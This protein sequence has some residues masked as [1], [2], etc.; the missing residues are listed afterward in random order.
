[1]P[2]GTWAR[3]GGLVPGARARRAQVA[4]YRDEWAGANAR[5]IGAGRAGPLWVA[6]G[7]SAA[8]GVGASAYDRG[9]VGQVLAHLRSHADRRWR[10]VNLSVSGATAPDVLDVQVPQLRRLEQ[11]IHLVTCIVGGNDLLR[12]P[13]NV[14]ETAMLAI[15]VALPEGSYVANLP[16]G[17]RERKAAR[18]NPSIEKAARTHGHRVI[19]LWARTGPP[20]AGK[21]SADHFHPN[22]RGYADWA[23][24]VIAALQLPS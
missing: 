18:L 17:V 4:R 8:Q 9:Y 1:M 13:R 10:V 21:F 19:D 7:D 6:L 12:T 11:P 16:R 5:A 15:C 23:A 2:M 14:T 24:A 3:L 20:W 22:D